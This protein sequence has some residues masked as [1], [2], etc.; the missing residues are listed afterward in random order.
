MSWLIYKHTNKLNGKVYIGQTKQTTDDRWQNGNGYKHNKYFYN[1]ILKYGWNSGFSHEIIEQNIESLKKANELEIYYINKERAYIGFK[2]CN[3]YNLTKGGEN[4]DHLGIPVAQ[5][6]KKA[7]EII[8]VFTTIRQAEESTSI[9][10]TLISKCCRKKGRTISA[11]GFY[12]AFLDE[13]SNRQWTPK[14]KSVNHDKKDYSVFQLDDEFN[15][16][17]KFKSQLHASKV[18]HIPSSNISNACNQK[19]GYIKP[20]GFYFC[21]AK[22]FENFSP[23]KSKQKYVSVVRIS[24]ENLSDIKIYLSLAEA[25]KDNSVSEK[26]ITNACNGI[27]IS[28][29]NFYWCFKENYNSNW[30]PR[31]NRNIVQVICVE[32]KELFNSISE[33]A[34]QK[35]INGSNIR[36]AC[37][38]S[39]FKAGGF[40]WAYANYFSRDY[41]IR[42]KKTTGKPV[43]CIETREIFDSATSAAKEM[44]LDNSEISKACKNPNKRCGGFH[45]KYIE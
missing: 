9:D 30:T 32:T 28:S 24:K 39:G 3:G 43:Q 10:H 42:E 19:R 5:I 45:W 34:T 16:I 13:F 18:L 44:G 29:A 25:A 4:R 33:A 23:L 35:G 8:N 17:N 38:D 11:G 1:A 27:T 21:Y 22:D 37:L 12:W 31:K 6:D 2:D 15:I 41:K 7:L 26:A 40:H 36:R 20:G 14:L